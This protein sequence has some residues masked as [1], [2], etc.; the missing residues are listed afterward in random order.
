MIFALIKSLFI[1]ARFKPDCIIGA[2]SFT[3]VPVIY[4]AKII[5]PKTRIIIHQQDIQKGLANRLC[6]KFAHKITV[7]TQNSL[8]DF[9]RE[10]TVYTGN[11]YRSEIMNGTVRDGY[12]LFNLE[13]NV[14]T[15]LILG[16]SAGAEELNNVVAAALPSLAKF[17]QIIHLAGKNKTLKKTIR[18]PRYHA[19]PFITTNLSHA[20]A[21]S[22]IVVSRAGFSTI[23]ELSVLA[24]PSI[25]IPI[26]ASH[27]E[28]NADWL[29]QN[30][31]AVVLSQKS[32]TS[33]VFVKQI[34]SLIENKEKLFT[35]SSA[36]S[37][38][39]PKDACER[40]VQEIFGMF[41]KGLE[42]RS[43]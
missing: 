4:A 20:Y 1:L 15:A 42:I 17:L 34:Q 2:G 21:V 37:T 38:L 9:S 10:K 5:S 43:W 28:A 33:T 13:K 11:P 8:V 36:I 14:P 23:T 7:A 27:Q 26:P 16:G 19:Y 30:N 40:V 35:L 6:E 12:S 24:K 41:E 3:E 22:D 25:I 29:K 18:H 32:L 39:L 31:A